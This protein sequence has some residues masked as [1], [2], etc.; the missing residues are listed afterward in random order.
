MLKVSIF[1]RQ[2]INLSLHFRQSFRLLTIFWR[3]P[4]IPPILS[5][6]CR[7][8]RFRSKIKVKRGYH[9]GHHGEDSSNFMKGPRHARQE[10]TLKL[11]NED[12]MA[13]TI[14]LLSAGKQVYYHHDKKYFLSPTHFRNSR[15]P[16][17]RVG[18]LLSV[19]MMFATVEPMKLRCLYSLNTVEVPLS[20]TKM[21]Q[22]PHLAK[23]CCLKGSDSY[24]VYGLNRPP[25]PQF[26]SLIRCTSK[27]NP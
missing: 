14:V 19:D 26:A 3:P 15:A 13:M 20:S 16:R 18:I 25:A 17:M 23:Q 7:P 6:Q 8:F 12:I 27:I 9:Q 21:G 5:T 2:Q 24:S 10:R 4:L 11:G 22:Q 1:S